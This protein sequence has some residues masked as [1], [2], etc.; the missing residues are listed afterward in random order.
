LTIPLFIQ[1]SDIHGL[2]NLDYNVRIEQDNK[3]VN[4]GRRP[5]PCLDDIKYIRNLNLLYRIASLL[6]AT[7]IQNG[8]DSLL[9]NLGLL[10]QLRNFGED[11]RAEKAPMTKDQTRKTSLAATAGWNP[12]WVPASGACSD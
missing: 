2:I 9:N 5:R 4:K 11:G 7:A 3:K 10:K 1:L 12:K 8:D 6:R